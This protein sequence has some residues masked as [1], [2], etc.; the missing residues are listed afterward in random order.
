V[1]S[2]TNIVRISFSPIYERKE[3]TS[4]HLDLL[5]TKIFGHFCYC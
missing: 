3:E 2:I 1:L 4:M 5:D